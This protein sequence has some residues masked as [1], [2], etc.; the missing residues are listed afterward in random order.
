MYSANLFSYVF[1]YSLS[2]MSNFIVWVDFME[3][4]H[5][6]HGD[7]ANARRRLEL[8]PSSSLEAQYPNILT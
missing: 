6:I 3:V 4:A 7:L 5:F 2:K 1:K 8:K